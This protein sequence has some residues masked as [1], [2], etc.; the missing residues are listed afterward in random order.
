MNPLDIIGAIYMAGAAITAVITFGKCWDSKAILGSVLIGF[1]CSM[2]WPVAWPMIGY[3]ILARG[4]REH[5]EDSAR[6][7]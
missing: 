6:T 7:S 1:A 4:S 3:C 2:L 5:H